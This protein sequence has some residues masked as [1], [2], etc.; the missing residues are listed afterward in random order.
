MNLVNGVL[1]IVFVPVAVHRLGAAGYGLFSIYTV[2]AGYVALTD[3]GVGPNLQRLLAG[4]PGGKTAGRPEAAVHEIQTAWG[5]YLLLSAGLLLL[6]IAL[7]HV[8][9]QYLFPVAPESRRVVQ[10]ITAFAVFDWVLGLPVLLL[11]N[12]CAAAERFDRYSRFTLASGLV[13]YG[14]MFAGV[15]LTTRPEVVAGLIAA[16]RLL[17]LPLALRITGGLPAGAW[18]PRFARDSFLRFL[19][20]SSAMSAAQLVQV[21]VVAVPAVL[22]NWFFG[23]RPLGVY[24]ATFDL[25]NRIWFFSNTIAL[26]LFPKFVRMLA[27]TRERLALQG[28]LPRL[29]SLS[30]IAYGALAIAGALVGPT[31]LRA[32]GLGG[33][34]YAALFVALIG[35]LS[36]N[37]H[38][39]TAYVFHLAAGR[40]LRAALLGLIALILLLGTFFAARAAGAGLFAIAW[41]WAASQLVYAFAVD[42]TALRALEAPVRPLRDAAVRVIIVVAVAL[43]V[44]TQLAWLPPL[45]APLSVL[46]ALLA[47]AV[48][49]HEWRSLRAFATGAGARA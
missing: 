48:G 6:L 47:L 16:R 45:A 4:R 38:G 10:W 8:V 1:G 31:A 25:V 44:L 42:L 5:F 12:T 36:F 49:P 26:V 11:Q 46:L 24:R 41:G 30:W 23:I 27:G 39:T 37:A 2:V 22:V 29:L 28:I 15:L 14:L 3:L 13:R 43:A 18:R 9:P 33:A 21:S 19:A 17:D 7:L 35:A 32:I 40:P 34:E 20:G